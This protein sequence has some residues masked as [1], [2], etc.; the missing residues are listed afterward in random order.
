MFQERVPTHER[1]PT[2]EGKWGVC[3]TSCQDRTFGWQATRD[4]EGWRMSILRTLTGCAV[5]RSQGRCCSRVADVC[6]KTESKTKD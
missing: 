5:I 6:D 3:P 4:R 2:A 1:G